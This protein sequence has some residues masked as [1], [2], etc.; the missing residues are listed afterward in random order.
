MALSSFVARLRK[1]LNL[2]SGIRTSAEALGAPKRRRMAKEDFLRF[3]PSRSWGRTF[4]TWGIV[5]VL[6]LALNW[7]FLTFTSSFGDMHAIY[8]AELAYNAVHC[9][10]ASV[11]PRHYD[12][13]SLAS[14]LE[15]K[16]KDAS[17]RQC[18][19]AIYAFQHSENS[20]RMVY[21]V[22][23]KVAPN[24]TL[25][26]IGSVLFCLKLALFLVF[27]LA[28]TR[29]GLGGIPLFLIFSS[30][31]LISYH[32]N[33]F[34]CYS[35]LLPLTLCLIGLLFFNLH[36][37]LYKK[38]WGQGV[39][40][41]GIG[42]YSHF[43]IEFRTTYLFIIVCLLGV[44]GL[45]AQV[46]KRSLLL[47]V[48]IPTLVGCTLAQYGSLRRYYVPRPEIVSAQMPPTLSHSLMLSLSLD[49]AKGLP[50]KF[51]DDD[52][53]VGIARHFEP[54][55]IFYDAESD[56]VLLQYY[57]FLWKSYSPDMAKL[58]AKR[59]LTQQTAA[60]VQETRQGLSWTNAIYMVPLIWTEKL[61]FGWGIL[62]HFLF[63]G[64][65]VL[66]WR[67]R[68]FLSPS[69]LFIFLSLG[70]SAEMMMLASFA[71]YPLA[72]IAYFS[73]PT[74]AGYVWT[75]SIFS[76]QRSHS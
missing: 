25:S 32:I 15:H 18:D 47:W 61:L 35:W 48:L 75:V 65:I 56:P 1:V 17:K 11:L 37:K 16:D 24:L 59:L 69:F 45:C 20:L 66:L 58:Y 53:G 13:K 40:F 22:I 57:L 55:L 54:T 64:S 7:S 36:E 29:G 12:A 44:Y 49:K 28:L 68:A 42:V 14:L 31:L 26:H 60:S 5:T 43:L 3:P 63:I 9:G 4:K 51:W 8:S 52:T 74:F 33:A 73:L 6:G 70:I 72:H 67:R 23:F 71:L 76:R 41:L 46:K 50:A 30:Y 62:A 2:S 27:L 21:E 38:G 39:F 10:K 34:S 19:Q